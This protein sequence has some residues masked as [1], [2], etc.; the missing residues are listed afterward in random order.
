MALDAN[1]FRV[2]ELAARLH[3]HRRTVDRWIDSGELQAIHLRSRGARRGLRLISETAVEAMLRRHS[4]EA[5]AV[6]VLSWMSVQ[7]K[8]KAGLV[9]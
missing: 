3:V 1:Y 5:N 9:G 4:D 2:G 8:K 6:P 7:R